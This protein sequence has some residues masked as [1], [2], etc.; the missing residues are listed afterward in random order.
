[1]AAFTKE[2]SRI[3]EEKAKGAR[4]RSRLKWNQWNERSAKYYNN[5]ELKS[6]KKQMIRSL[7]S[8]GN[9][10]ESQTQIEDQVEKYYKTLFEKEETCPDIR[11]HFVRNLEPLSRKVIDHEDARTENLTD[12]ELQ[13][14]LKSMRKEGS[15]GING[16]TVFL[17]ISGHA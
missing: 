10:F 7:T 13:G 16:F 2:S 1:M 14:A 12:G 6:Q 5:I 8:D 9:T 11:N 17:V 15:P 4:V 3:S